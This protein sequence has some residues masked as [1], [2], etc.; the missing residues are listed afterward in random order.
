MKIGDYVFFR[1]PDGDSD[2]AVIIA[3]KR[4]VVLLDNGFESMWIHRSMCVVQSEEALAPLQ[5]AES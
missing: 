3:E 5:E 4:A 2:S 1:R